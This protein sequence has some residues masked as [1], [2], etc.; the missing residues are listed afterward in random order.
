[1]KCFTLVFRIDDLK[2]DDL[3]IDDLKTDDP[4]LGFNIFRCSIVGMPF[5]SQQ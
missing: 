1:M 4:A 2:I 3:K 5:P